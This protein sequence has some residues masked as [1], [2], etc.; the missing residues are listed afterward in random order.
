M[1]QKTDSKT[2]TANAVWIA[3]A[4]LHMENKNRKDFQAKEIFQKVKDLDITSSS[5]ATLRT[6]ISHHC[7][8]NLPPYPNKDRKLYRENGRYRLFKA[9]DIAH[10]ERQRG[11]TTP[12]IDEIPHQFR[13]T[14]QWYLTEYFNKITIDTDNIDSKFEIFYS[15]V[16]ENDVAK[17]PP[18]IMKILKP[19]LGE[20]LLFFYTKDGKIE[21]KKAS[22]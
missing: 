16:L 7:V 21:I 10:P 11:Q 3:T 6:H 13:N 5:D 9:G 19:K 18:G 1:I 20:P 2:T 15:E 22:T 8:A 4:L 14:L 12:T 17:I